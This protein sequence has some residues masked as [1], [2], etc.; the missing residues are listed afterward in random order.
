MTDTQTFQ[1][2]GMTCEHCVRAVTTEVS[3]LDGVD[4]VDVVLNPDGASTVTVAASGPV[5]PE[6]IIAAIDEAGYE[7]AGL[8]E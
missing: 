6:L 8:D 5:A 3:S 2:A 4:T 1:V 7:T